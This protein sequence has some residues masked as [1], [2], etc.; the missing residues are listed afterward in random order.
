MQEWADNHVTVVLLGVRNRAA[1]LNWKQRLD[2]ARI[3]C[4]V[5]LEPDIGEGEETALAVHP[6]VDSDLFRN[7]QLL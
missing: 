1:L 2:D 4:E 6:S 3:V 5:F 7:L